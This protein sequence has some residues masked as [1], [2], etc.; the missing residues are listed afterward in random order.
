MLQAYRVK[1]NIVT[2]YKVEGMTCE[3]CVKSLSNAIAKAL[4]QSKVS[5]DLDQGLVNVDGPSDDTRMANVVEMAGFTY[6]GVAA[7]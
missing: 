3:G 4:P 2:T 1:E 6:Q 7:K 5:I